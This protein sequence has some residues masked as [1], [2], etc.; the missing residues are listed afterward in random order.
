MSVAADGTATLLSLET[1]AAAAR[2]RRRAESAE[3]RLWSVLDAVVDPEIPALS[4]WDL[5][6]LQDVH[7]I[8]H[9]VVV[10]LTPTYSGCPALREIGAAVT[11]ALQDAGYASVDVQTRL[12]PVW[13]TDGMTREARQRLR[14]EGISPPGPSIDADAP[15]CPRCNTRNVTRISAFAGTACRAMF[16]CGACHEVFDHFKAI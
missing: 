5:G 15:A 3:P 10:I 4:L 2:I 12:S 1:A 9:K 14:S 11:Q 13:S 7:R 16:R 6:I 8:G